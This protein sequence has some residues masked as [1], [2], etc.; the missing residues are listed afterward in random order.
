MKTLLKKIAKKMGF[1]VVRTDPSTSH[2]E[3][4]K[5]LLA[6]HGIDLVLDVGASAGHYGKFLRDFGYTGKIISFEPLST[7]YS[8]LEVVSRNDTL[9]TVAARTAIGDVDGSIEIN[10][11]GNSYSSS[12][13]DMLDS[14]LKAAPESAYIGSEVVRISKLD[15][16]AKGYLEGGNYSIFLKIDVQ[17]FE[18]QV[19]R[20]AS[21][22][23]KVIKG[24]Q[25]ELSLIPLYKEQILFRE[26]LDKMERLGYELHAILPG[27]T[28]PETGRLLQMDGIFFKE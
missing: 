1:E 28:D 5:R 24:V 12:I 8:E 27:F 23:L 10:V 15:T 17:G 4:M 9:W 21:Q 25:M 14:H 18:A 11:S 7:A 3:R 13:L 20:G 2:S 16:I 22:V 26:M 6:H 19:L